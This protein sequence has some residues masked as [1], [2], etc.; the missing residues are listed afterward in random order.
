[1]RRTQFF[2]YLIKVQIADFDRFSKL[3]VLLGLKILF[4][5]VLNV[6]NIFSMILNLA[7]W[8]IDLNYSKLH[9][10]PCNLLTNLFDRIFANH[11]VFLNTVFINI[12]FRIHQLSTFFYSVNW[13]ELG[14]SRRFFWHVNLH[15]NDCNVQI[16]QIF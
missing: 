6:L 16:F 15:E 7:F 8:I 1:M 5:R 12:F 3:L 11:K 10:D 2:C 9:S 4:Q 14:V 13:F